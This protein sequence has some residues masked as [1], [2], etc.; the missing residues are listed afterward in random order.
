MSHSEEN[1]PEATEQQNGNN[2]V[3][4]FFSS[5][6]TTIPSDF[7]SGFVAIVGR[8]N[9]GKST[10][11]NH[12]LGQKLSITSR[13]PQTTRHKIVGIDSREK[14]QAVFVDTPGMHKKEVRA[15]NKMMNRAAHSALRDVNLVLFVVDAQKWTQNDELVLEKL[16]NADMPVI[17][18]INKLDTFENKNE[19]LPLIR[20]RAKL[21]NFAEIVPVSALRGANL[22]HLRDTIEKYLPYQP[23]LY[24][25]DQI[26]DRSE[27]FLA[28]EIIRE[29]IMRQ[30]GE[31]LPYDLTVQI[32]S[33]KTEEA[34][35]N[36][37]TGRLKPPCTYIDATIF[38]ERQGQKAIVIG[39]KG[40]KLKSI[41]MDARADMEKMFEQKI[42]LTLW[43]KVKGGWSDDERALKSL[44]YSDI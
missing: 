25:L 9:V 1:K 36:E 29:K 8:P 33:F 14:S 35:V 42:M 7:K 20:E 2:V 38:V 31:E 26:T 30:L 40:A 44:G 32:E 22:D 6:G 13:K 18:V 4:Q 5:Q 17:L 34:T 10:L 39:D 23:P 21:M 43:V 12:I 16:K 37:K 28:S 15:I 19:A 3:D 41:G 24:S 11:M 27:R